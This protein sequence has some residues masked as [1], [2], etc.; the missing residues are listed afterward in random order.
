MLKK[1]YEGG[2]FEVHLFYY[3]RPSFIDYQGL[4]IYKCI[5]IHKNVMELIY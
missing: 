3:Y 4:Y 2:T 1:F 5:N